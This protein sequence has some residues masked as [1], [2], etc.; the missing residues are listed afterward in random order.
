[1]RGRD[2][3]RGGSGLFTTSMMRDGAPVGVVEHVH[4]LLPLLV[5]GGAVQTQTREPAQPEVVL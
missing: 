1:M 5:A 4:A 2:G 3:T